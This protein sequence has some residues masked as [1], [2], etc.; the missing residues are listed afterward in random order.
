MN[1]LLINQFFFIK[2]IFINKIENMKKVIRLTESDLARIVKRVISEQVPGGTNPGNTPKAKFNFPDGKQFPVY[3]PEITSQEKLNSFL[4]W[5]AK[6][7]FDSAK[8]LASKG[9]PGLQTTMTSVET[10]KEKT[11]APITDDEMLK[12]KEFLTRVW[13]SVNLGLQVVAKI[14]VKGNY[15]DTVHQQI[16]TKIVTPQNA[17]KV[18]DQYL[19]PSFDKAF[20]AVLNGQ[21]AKI[22]Q[23]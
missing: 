7:S 18:L 1:L 5:G 11:G 8:I 13:E 15:M 2:H 14:G 12:R 19:Q 20:I 22:K 9:W 16:N 4:D 3:L 23:G 6:N 21:I 10:Q 17:T